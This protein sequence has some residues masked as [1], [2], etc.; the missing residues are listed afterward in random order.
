M[1]KGKWQP[2]YKGQNYYREH[3]EFVHDNCKYCGG[4]FWKKV[5]KGLFCSTKC[6]V[7]WH[8][9]IM[10]HVRNDTLC[11][12]VQ[13]WKHLHKEWKRRQNKKERQAS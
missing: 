1:G 9:V 2:H 10:A 5:K 12:T 7:Y 3:G 8:R 13:W 6:R 11:L 4:K